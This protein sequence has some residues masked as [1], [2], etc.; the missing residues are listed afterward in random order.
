MSSSSF[1]SSQPTSRSRT[2]LFISYRDSRARSSRFSR[3]PAASSYDDPDAGSNENEGLMSSLPGHVSLDVDLP[4]KWYLLLVAGHRRWPLAYLCRS[5]PWRIGLISLTKLRIYWEGHT[6]R[7][8]VLD[9]V[10]CGFKAHHPVSNKR[11]VVTALE[12]LH[13]KHALPGFA[14]RSA[15]EREIEAATTDITRVCDIL[16]RLSHILYSLIIVILL[17]YFFRIRTFDNVRC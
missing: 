7:V 16:Q 17:H 13:A 2:L 5:L 3:S 10:P 14:D 8:R 15:E 11:F 4:P 6:P 12:K 1:S 9:T